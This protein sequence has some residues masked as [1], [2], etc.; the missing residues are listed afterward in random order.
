MDTTT[1]LYAFL[2]SVFMGSYPVPIKTPAVLR[3]NVHPIVFQCYKSFWVFV[4]GFGFVVVRAMR[5]DSPIFAFS[6][7]GVASAVA[8]V[9]CFLWHPAYFNLYVADPKRTLH[10]IQRSAH[11]H[12]DGG[13][14]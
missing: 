1:L 4:T 6:W 13:C 14:S 7:W 8:W 12:V 10:N 2:G 5:G 11:R 3:A 9:R